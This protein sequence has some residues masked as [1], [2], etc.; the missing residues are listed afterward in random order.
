MQIE[1][2]QIGSLLGMGDKGR[3]SVVEF[4]RGVAV[5]KWDAS[6]GACS[7]VDLAVRRP[8]L[9]HIAA[10]FV[11]EGPVSRDYLEFQGTR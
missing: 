7:R 4:D 11:P 10:A 1:I 3:S 9:Q 8:L 5:Y 6:V 2:A